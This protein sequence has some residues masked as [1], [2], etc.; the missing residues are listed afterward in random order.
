MRFLP[1][2]Y[3][4][5]M[6]RLIRQCI[7]IFH[8]WRKSRRFSG[9]DQQQRPWPN[10]LHLLFEADIFAKMPSRLQNTPRKLLRTMDVVFYLVTRQ[11]ALLYLDETIISLVN[12]EVHISHV[13]GVLS[14]SRNY[15]ITWNHEN[16]KFFV[17]KTD[18]L[19]HIIRLHKIELTDHSTN[20][21]CNLKSLRNI[22]KMK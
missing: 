5:Q 4:G 13:S 21:V 17:E 16:H 20:T 14:L 11:S 1:Y 18:Y 2:T 19:E 9:R 7:S 12:A 22:T 3:D 15:A 8:I 6:Y 10:S